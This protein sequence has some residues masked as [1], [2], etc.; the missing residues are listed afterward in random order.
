MTLQWSKE[1]I[2]PRSRIPGSK[3]E[4]WHQ[5]TLILV[6]VEEM[7]L[8]MTSVGQGWDQNNAGW[9][10]CKQDGEKTFSFLLL[11]WISFSF[12]KMTIVWWQDAQML[13]K[14]AWFVIVSWLKIA[15]SDHTVFLSLARQE[16][17]TKTVTRNGFFEQRWNAYKP[18]A[19]NEFS[20]W[21]QEFIPNSYRQCAQVASLAMESAAGMGPATSTS[22]DFC[23][24]EDN[25]V[26]KWGT[27][28]KWDFPFTKTIFYSLHEDRKAWTTWSTH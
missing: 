2:N 15:R 17:C 28:Q 11:F 21:K 8:M 1:K 7:C 6:K 24:H 26:A 13:L 18:G 23:L 22:S 3:L 12:W 10:F 20:V 16:K 5:R 25:C 9:S 27:W 4:K 19:F 14:N